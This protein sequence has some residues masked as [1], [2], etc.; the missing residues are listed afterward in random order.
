MKSSV[1]IRFDSDL[2]RAVRLRQAMSPAV[3]AR[4]VPLVTRRVFGLVQ[5]HFRAYAQTHHATADALGAPHTKH[6]ERAARNMAHETAREGNVTVG[7]VV[8]KMAGI[9]RAFHDVDIRMGDRRL[10]IPIARESY[11]RSV[12]EMRARYGEGSLFC[13]RSRKGS[14]IM[15]ARGERGRGGGRTRVTIPLFVLKESVHQRRDPDMVPPET[16]ISA[17]AKAALVACIERFVGGG[18]LQ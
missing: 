11:G 10:T 12:A 18:G 17:A 16:A 3:H 1:Q 7:R 8:L 14:T 2:E 6:M 9:G 4:I 13:F 15:A 5:G